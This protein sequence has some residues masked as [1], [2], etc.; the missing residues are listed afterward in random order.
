[1]LA[2]L[3]AMLRSQVGRIQATKGKGERKPETRLANHGKNRRMEIID[4][5]MN[6]LEKGDK[7]DLSKSQSN[8]L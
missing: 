4:G 8:M 5:V 3:L 6:T 2:P 7:H 1:M